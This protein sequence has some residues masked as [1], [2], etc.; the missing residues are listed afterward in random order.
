M[1]NKEKE[2][3]YIGWYIFVG[4]MFIGIGVD[5]V[6]KNPGIGTMIGMGTGFLAS[7]IYDAKKIK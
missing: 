3:D 1:E 5:S 6:L 2:S 4:F 7:A